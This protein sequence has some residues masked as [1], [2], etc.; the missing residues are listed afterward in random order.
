M[1]KVIVSQYFDTYFE[2]KRQ[3]GND[4]DSIEKAKN[5]EKEAHKMYYNRP[6]VSYHIEIVE[7]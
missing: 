5:I 1:F 4:S 3:Y 6:L 2:W 7:A